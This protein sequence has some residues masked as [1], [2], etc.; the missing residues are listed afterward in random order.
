[1]NR[2]PLDFLLRVSASSDTEPH[3]GST[4]ELSD[5]EEEGQNGRTRS[6]SILVEANPVLHASQPVV[7]LVVPLPSQQPNA[8]GRPTVSS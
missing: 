5:S 2:G 8:S 1:M 3:L 7:P 6:P 4:E